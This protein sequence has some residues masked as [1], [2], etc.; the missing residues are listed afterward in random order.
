[1]TKKPTLMAQVI[2]DRLKDYINCESC[3]LGPEFIDMVLKQRDKIAGER[4][5]HSRGMAPETNWGRRG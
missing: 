2:F 1:M 3:T 4:S 5:K